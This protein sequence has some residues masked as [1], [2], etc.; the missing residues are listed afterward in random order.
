MAIRSTRAPIKRGSRGRARRPGGTT[1]LRFDLSPVAYR[2]VLTFLYYYLLT[3]Y[4]PFSYFHSLL[5]SLLTY[6]LLSLLTF[7]FYSP[8]TTH[9]LLTFSSHIFI[10]FSTHHLLSLLIFSF[11]SPLTTHLLLTFPPYIF[12]HYSPSFFL[13]LHFSQA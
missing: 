1:P 4:F 7:L 13:L 10:L 11:T 6:N 2:I 9:L 12:I 8:L 5:H 3:T